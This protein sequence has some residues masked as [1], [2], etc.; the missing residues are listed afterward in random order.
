M[1]AITLYQYATWLMG[2]LLIGWLYWRALRGRDEAA[3]LGEKRGQASVVRPKGDIVW[4]HAASVGETLSV[5]HLISDI[6]AGYQSVTILLTTG[7]RS[8]A[9]IAGD[10]IAGQP[11]IQLIHQFIPLDRRLWVNKFLDHWQPRLALFVESEIWPN[12]LTELAHRNIPTALVNGRLSLTS[13]RR[14]QKIPTIA[15][16]LLAHFSLIMAQDDTTK[17]RL[18]QLTDQPIHTPGHLKFDAPPLAA[19]AAQLAALRQAIG[20]RTCWLAASTHA[21]EEAMVANAHSALQPAF[22]D[23][24][25]L[26]APRHPERGDALAS[27]MRAMGLSVKQ[28]SKGELPTAN[29]AIYLADTIGEMGLFFCVVNLVLVGGTLVAHGGQNPLEPARLD[30]AILHG[31]STDNFAEIFNGLDKSGGA[32]M[33]END[34]A[35]APIVQ[36]LLSDNMLRQ[37]IAQQATD[38]AGNLRGTRQRVLALLAPYLDTDFEAK[39][40]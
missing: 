7:S 24:L 11:N 12:V 9:K 26:I 4:V 23:L 17:A 32:M 20:Q 14:W 6:L 29:T 31:T 40:G 36:T 34:A 16:S 5:L 35:L 19:N 25:T 1:R 10:Y 39:N 37:Q 28:R 8:S 13:F 30:C 3:R 18:H 38:Y 2:P 21:G 15:A 27:Q 33:I 22:T